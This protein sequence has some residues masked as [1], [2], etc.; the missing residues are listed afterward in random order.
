[1]VTLVILFLYQ[2]AAA[3][4]FGQGEFG[5]DV[6]FGSATS[7][8]IS[9]GGDVSLPLQP[10][11]PHFSGSGSHMVTVT[12]TDVVGYLLYAH[13]TDS[14]DMVNGSTT[15]PTSN[16]TVAGPLVADSWGYNTTSSTTNFLG[17][18]LAPVLLKDAAGPY[19]SGDNTI[20]TYG[21]LTGASKEAGSYTTSVTYTAVAKNQ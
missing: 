18:T 7:L 3:A 11:G 9:L 12:S 8:T 10:D 1:M 5:T 16:N 14:T 15:I 13:S 17:M 20:V 2:Q 4:P 21:A 19:K 6:P